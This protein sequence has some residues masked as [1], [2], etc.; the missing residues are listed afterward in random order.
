MLRFETQPCCTCHNDV[1]CCMNNLGKC[2][3]FT[4][5]RSANMLDKT[6]AY[7]C[8]ALERC[9]R[10]YKQQ[11]VNKLMQLKSQHIAKIQAL[12]AR[13]KAQLMTA[14]LC[15]Q[16]AAPYK[17]GPPQP[18]VQQ[19]GKLFVQ[20]HKR[21]EIEMINAQRWHHPGL[22]FWSLVAAADACQTTDSFAIA[23]CSVWGLAY[24]LAYTA[25]TYTLTAYKVPLAERFM[26][27]Q[28]SQ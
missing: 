27:A 21:S 17:P 11:R 14:L 12:Q 8:T 28:S 1:S 26:M 7:S 5:Q 25:F 15:L 16:L 23:I 24:E 18:S 4:C 3:T 19:I 13:R 2:S 9:S 20:P 22:A 10:K 6:Y